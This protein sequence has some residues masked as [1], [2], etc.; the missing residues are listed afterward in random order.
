MPDQIQTFN[1]SLI[2]FYR[3]RKR[4]YFFLEWNNDMRR[5]RKYTGDQRPFTLHVSSTQAPGSCTIS[6]TVARREQRV[7]IRCNGFFLKSGTTI[8]P[9]VEQVTLPPSLVGTEFTATAPE[10][11]DEYRIPQTLWRVVPP[12]PVQP[13]RTPQR[14]QIVV[15]RKEPIPRRIAWLIAEDAQK[16][17]ESCAIT[18]EDITPITAAVTTC[19]HVFN[20]DALAE[21][22]A[23][24]RLETIIPCPVCR[25]N[26]AM[27]RAYE[28]EPPP[29]IADEG[30]PENPIQVH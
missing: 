4:T 1:E 15:K 16:Q 23:R 28:D 18:M 7:Q 8:V 22:V 20:A 30:S 21:W 10:N 14:T 25:K 11:N 24:H 13:P 3:P 17:G 5:W 6:C 27:T 2:A 9:L 12:Q 26:F 29:L 19:F